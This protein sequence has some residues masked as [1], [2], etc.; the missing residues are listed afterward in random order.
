MPLTDRARSWARR[1][2]SPHVAHRRAGSGRDV[3]TLAA[4]RS[5]TDLAPAGRVSPR[6]A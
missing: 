6:R 1:A 5:S 4:S 3:R 2:H